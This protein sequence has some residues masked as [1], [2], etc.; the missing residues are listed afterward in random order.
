MDQVFPTCLAPRT[1]SGLRRAAV[2]QLRRRSSIPR[3]IAK[4]YLA[5][6]KSIYLTQAACR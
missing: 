1:I 2:F 4:R 6:R 3:L 5:Y